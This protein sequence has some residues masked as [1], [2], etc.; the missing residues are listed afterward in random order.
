MFKH[1]TAHTHRQTPSCH[2]CIYNPCIRAHTHAHTCMAVKCVQSQSSIIK[3]R[4]G[5]QILNFEKMS[6]YYVIFSFFVE[7]RPFSLLSFCSALPSHQ[8]LTL[9]FNQ[10]DLYYNTGFSYLVIRLIMLIRL[11][12]WNVTIINTINC[13]LLDIF[14]ILLSIAA[15]RKNKLFSLM[16]SDTRYLRHNLIFSYQCLRK[17]MEVI[18][19]KNPNFY[20]IKAVSM[21][22]LTPNR[23]TSNELSSNICT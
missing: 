16:F 11:M 21:I 22:S 18:F 12:Q 1:L 10:V 17:H 13:I 3:P 2:T 19:I 23:K 5:G 14:V 20:T 8:R 9:D 7:W 4:S 15:P 6:N